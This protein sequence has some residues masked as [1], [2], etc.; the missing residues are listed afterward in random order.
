[1]LKRPFLFLLTLTILLLVF[2]PTRVKADN[3]EATANIGVATDLSTTAY[4]LVTGLASEA[5]PVMAPV[6]ASHSPLAIGGL[7]ALRFGTVYY[8]DKKPEPDRTNNLTMLNAVT[9]GTVTNNVFV[10]TG[11]PHG[12]LFGTLIGYLYWKQT[13]PMR[14]FMEYC[15]NANKLEGIKKTCVWNPPAVVQPDSF[16]YKG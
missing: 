8:N 6:F 7:V 12:V 9:W 1:M 11:T 5:N 16:S 10:L 4:G 13:Q 15:T 2:I 14:E 3:L